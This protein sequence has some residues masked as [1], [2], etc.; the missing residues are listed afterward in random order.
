[1]AIALCKDGISRNE[2]ANVKPE[3]LTAG[4]NMLLHAMLH[5]AT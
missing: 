2:I 1:M 4:F 5:T 3:H